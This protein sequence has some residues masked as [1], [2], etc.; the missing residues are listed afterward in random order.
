[1]LGGLVALASDEVMKRFQQPAEKV[2]QGPVGPALTW[3]RASA[4]IHDCHHRLGSHDT[5]N[6]T[7][8]TLLAVIPVFEP[9]TLWFEAFPA[10]IVPDLNGMESYLYAR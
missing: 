7:G 2:S 10:K 6:T 9:N 8:S 4:F 3:R 5:R 1:M